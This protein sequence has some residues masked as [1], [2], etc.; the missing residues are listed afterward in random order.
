M[1][2]KF[3]KIRLFAVILSM[4]MLFC[5]VPSVSANVTERELTV[6]E[7]ISAQKQAVE[8]NEV[9]MQYFFAE[10]WVLEYP[11]YFGGCYIED[12]V[13]HIIL[14]EPTAVELEELDEVLSDYENAINFESG[15][16]SQAS[17][18]NYADNTAAELKKQGIEVTHWYVEI[19]TGDI[20]I[21]VVNSDIDT[22][23]VK[24][25]EIQSYTLRSSTPKIVI[26]EG[27][28]TST[29]SDPVIGGSTI[30]IG[31]SNR[32]AGTCGYF[33]GSSAMVTCGH[34]N[35]ATGSAVRMNGS[36]IGKVVDVQQMDRLEIIPSLS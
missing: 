14:V 24:I 1:K 23:N 32:S 16:Y 35:T 15:S 2:P 22:A 6:D 30:A 7:L 28:Y 11:D 5:S 31:N 25:A 8:A 21:G 36:L 9:L 10:G 26:E 27:E 19:E 18:Q 29:T 12:N 4:A 13:L 34:G 20:I 17:I 3:P 33:D